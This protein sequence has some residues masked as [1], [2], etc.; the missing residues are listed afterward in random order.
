M[1]D[2]EKALATQ[3]SN[4]EKRTG[5]SLDELIKIVNSSEFTKHGELVA[6]LKSTLGMGH[7]DANTLIHIVRKQ[8]QTQPTE[9]L[10]SEA[11]LAFLYTDK[12]ASLQPIHDQ[13]LRELLKIG[14]FEVAPK[15]NYIS[16]RGNKQFCTIGPATNTQVEIG[17]NVKGLE[18]SDRL[19][20]LP[21][22]QMCNY[23]VR[24]SDMSEI[25]AQL[26]EWIKAAYIAA[27]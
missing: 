24:L 14:D 26:M 22:G 6:M 7:G 23:K 27:T 8:G 13:L 9:P 16:Y 2:I 19:K 15:K 10:S 5:L 11:H 21:S 18:A 20:A 12:K 4:I 17:L 3:L 25:D 1:S